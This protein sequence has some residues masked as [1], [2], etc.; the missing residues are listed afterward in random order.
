MT[1][2]EKRAVL[3]VELRLWGMHPSWVLQVEGI[4]V[5]RLERLVRYL[6]KRSELYEFAKVAR[7]NTD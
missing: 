7:P 3:L 6:E 5:D 1:D 4:S 2:Q